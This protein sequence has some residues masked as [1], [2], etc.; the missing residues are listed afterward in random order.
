M[1]TRMPHIENAYAVTHL[2]ILDATL[3]AQDRD[4]DGAL[5]SVRALMNTG[6]SFGDEPSRASQGCRTS[7]GGTGVRNLERVLAQGEATAA[8]LE[9]LQRLLDDEARQPLQLI[10][11]RSERALVYGHLESV[12]AGKFNRAAWGMTASPLGS[13]ADD[14]I[15]RGRAFTSEAAYLQYLTK[16]VEIAK[17]PPEQQYDPLS[18]LHEPQVVPPKL[19]AAIGPGYDHRRFNHAFHQWLALMRCGSVALAAERYRLEHRR[20]PDDLKP[21]VPQFL[22]EVPVD[23]F[24][25]MP[26]RFLRL[27]DGLEVYSIGPDMQDNGGKIF[28]S[29]RTDGQ[30]WEGKDIGFRLWDVEQRGR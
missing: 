23:P 20:W 22:R 12:R 29:P 25:G 16:Y 15:D 8:D 19:L 27:N 10:A 2:L 1:A 21:L 17:L 28:R 7:F 5:V 14:F 24:D 26:L 6:R 4:I 13:K 9:D 30:G 18:E 11:A 3:R